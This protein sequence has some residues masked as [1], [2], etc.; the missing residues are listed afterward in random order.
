MKS[1]FVF[2]EMPFMLKK[3]LTTRADRYFEK[4]TA[5]PVPEKRWHGLYDVPLDDLK[6]RAL[7]GDADAAF[8]LGDIYDQG[9]CNVTLDRAQAVKWYEKA[10]ALGHGDA[11]NNIASMYQHGDGPFPVDLLKARDYYERGVKAGCGTAMGNLGHFYADGRA[12]L[13]QDQRRAVKLFKQ[14]AHRGDGDSMVSLGYR[15]ST[16]S[17]VRKSPVRAL[18]WYRRALQVGN[19]RGANNLGVAYYYGTVVKEDAEK[20]VLLLFAALEGGFERAAYTLGL[21]NEKGKGTERDLEEALYLFRRAR[22]DDHEDADE[23]I[24]RVLTKMGEA[25]SPAIDPE[26]RLEDLRIMIRD[27][28]RRFSVEALLLELARV[29]EQLLEREENPA[30]DHAHVLGRSSLIRGFVLWKQRNP[31][32]L[33]PVETALAI[34]GRHPF[35]TPPE[36]AS[37]MTARAVAF[38]RD[39]KWQEAV[40]LHR[41]ALTIMKAD[42]EAEENAVLAAMTDLAFCL[43]EA[44]EFEEARTLNAE[45]LARAELAFG[46]DDPALLRMIG[47]LAHN[48][49]A[50]NHSNRSVE[51]MRRQLAIAE[52][53]EILDVIG[54]TLRDLAIASFSAG[55]LAG[56]EDLFRRQ[57]AFAER[58]GDSHDIARA[59]EDL[60]GLFERLEKMSR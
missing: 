41:G 51:L 39:R 40:D 50:L 52:Q 7:S 58:N 29:C 56:A 1:N 35:L 57:V 24:E 26:Q 48:E 59:R 12:G 31:A 21:A 23:A 45:A 53:H 18:Y 38:A 10:A 20:G 6:Q 4:R 15:Y 36:R 46:K 25:F 14:G 17:G 27:P 55:D 11:M 5:G 33:E 19:P 30:A 28:E 22:A 9:Y 3:Y 34:D 60:T 13:K 54:A 49:L 43:H 32:Y 47:N 16:G 42:P 8:V 44:A 2:E 37:L